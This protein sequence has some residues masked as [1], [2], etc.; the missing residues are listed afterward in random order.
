MFFKG[1]IMKRSLISLIFI[2][3][4]I[5]T[6]SSK[7][8]ASLVV[9]NKNDRFQ[10]LKSAE[11]IFETNPNQE[12]I[13]IRLLGAVKR[14]GLYHI[15]KDLD[16]ATLLSLA[17]GTTR[18]A[19]LNNIIIGNDSVK[20]INNVGNVRINLSEAIS[21]ANGKIYKL[22]YHDIVLVEDRKPAI[23]GD[24]WKLISIISIF[25]TSALTAIAINDRI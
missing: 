21:K 1:D 11:Y 2:S 7:S 12:L 13:S 23:S 4:L 22:K 16:L 24:T 20:K 6:S 25:L 10:L 9:N 3:I 14:A 19:D 15:P 18:E 17:G 5:F 8:Y